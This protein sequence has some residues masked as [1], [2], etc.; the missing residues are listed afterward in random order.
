MRAKDVIPS[1]AVAVLLITST[2]VSP[3]AS[4]DEHPDLRQSSNGIFLTGDWNGDGVDTPGLFVPGS[5][6]IYY[7]R[8]SNTTGTAD[9][10][11]TFGRGGFPVAGD[12]DGNG[13]DTI[14]LVAQG[15]PNRYFLRNSNTTGTADI[16]LVYGSQNYPVVGD[17]DGNG[18]DTV[19]VVARARPNTFHLRNSNTSGTADITLTYGDVGNPIAGDW[20]NDGIDTVGLVQLNET[21]SAAHQWLLRNTNS[22]GVADVTFRYGFGG[23][24]ITGDWNGD[25]IDTPGL[26]YISHPH[27]W[28]IHNHNSEGLDDFGFT[29]GG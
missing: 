7:L 12:W 28:Y 16:A 5:P 22:S 17:W 10:T 29:F 4:A 18:A 21:G 15:N 1:A 3:A 27:A 8:N 11:L 13:E 25:G 20:D 19:G 6:N 24:Q 26:T 9:I 2:L 23:R 14:G